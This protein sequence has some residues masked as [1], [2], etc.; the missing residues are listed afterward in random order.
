MNIEPELIWGVLR[1]Y[2]DLLDH[3]KAVSRRSDQIALVNNDEDVQEINL[4]SESLLPG[5]VSFPDKYF[6]LTFSDFRESDGISYAGK[7]KV[8]H[9]KE[10]KHLIL[11][12]KKMVFN[13]KI[14][15]QI[16]VLKK[17]PQF[18]IYDLDENRDDS[19]KSE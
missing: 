3:E 16:F 6:E 17:P 5:L 10:K 13:R 19:R 2:P 18:T 14:P 9:R 7:V 8:T 15:D 4:S 12:N 11:K 1:G